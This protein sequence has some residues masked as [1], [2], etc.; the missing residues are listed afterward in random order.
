VGVASCIRQYTPHL[1][2]NRVSGASAGAIAATF[3][4]CDA[5]I[6]EVTKLLLDVATQARSRTLGPFSPSFNITKILR[7]GM[8][9]LLP[10]DAHLRANGKLHIS[11][12]RCH[13]RK[14]IIVSQFDSREELLEVVMCAT[15]IPG[16]SG[17]VPPKYRGARHMDG[18]FT[19]NLPAMDEHTVTVSPYCGEADICP[20]DGN[21]T[22]MMFNIS[23]TSFELSAKNLF[24][25]SSTF[26][27]PTPE[28]LLDI[29]QQ[30][31]QNNKL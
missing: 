25:L 1:V 20:K 30:G 27:P 19:D 15:F 22:H 7:A 24:R 29:C 12:T 17:L 21:S 26:F 10:A 23:N 5:S 31:T 6:S 14:N 11:L 18:G 8:D 3:L 9:R 13:D 4:L 28:I 2:R 16:F